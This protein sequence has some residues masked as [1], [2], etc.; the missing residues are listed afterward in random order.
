MFFMKDKKQEAAKIRLKD[1]EA[2]HHILMVL[3]YLTAVKED[4]EL[5]D[6]IMAAEKKV[7]KK[8]DE[9]RVLVQPPKLRRLW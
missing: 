7:L 1:L 6:T 8:G 2:V 4:K 3:T 5:V 9:L